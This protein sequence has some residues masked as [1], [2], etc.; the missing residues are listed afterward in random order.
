MHPEPPKQTNEVKNPPIEYFGDTNDD[1]LVNKRIHY[2]TISF[3]DKDEFWEF[4]R[5]ASD[6]NFRK[7]TIEAIDVK[8]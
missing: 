4:V 5:S 3:E 6:R 1:L 8:I 7:M 2:V